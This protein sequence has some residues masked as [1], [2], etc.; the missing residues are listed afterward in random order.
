MSYLIWRAGVY[1]VQ[2]LWVWHVTQ[3]PFHNVHLWRSPQCQAKCQNF[4]PFNMLK[5][6][7]CHLTSSSSPS[8]TS[9]HSPTPPHICTTLHHW[10]DSSYHTSRSIPLTAQQ[11]V[12]TQPPS[13]QRDHT[14][15]ETVHPILHDSEHTHQPTPCTIH[16]STQARAHTVPP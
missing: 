1:C 4:L 7:L 9:T 8:L 3:P 12:L 5:P 13:R 11:R 10:E 2:Y 16:D 6:F 15:P 14:T